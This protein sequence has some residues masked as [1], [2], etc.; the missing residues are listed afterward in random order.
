MD[1][2]ITTGNNSLS[3]IDGKVATAANQTTGNGTLSTISGKVSLAANQITGG[4]STGTG[5][6]DSR[7]VRTVTCSDDPLITHLSSIASNTANIP[8]KGPATA[9]NSLPV[10]FATDASSQ[11]LAGD[12]AAGSSDSGKP[13]KIGGVYSSSPT[14]YA[15]GARVNAAFDHN[16]K[17]ITVHCLSNDVALLGY[18]VH[19]KNSS[20]S[21]N[22]TLIKS[23][24]GLVMEVTVINWNAA[25]R[26]LRLYDKATAPTVGTDIAYR[27]IAL[28]SRTPVTMSFPHGAYFENGIGYSMTTGNTYNDATGVAANEIQ[29]T[30]QWL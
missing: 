16:G 27:V 3:S 30:I 17:Q 1:G 12:V 28:T 26:Y 7:T 9:A 8:A 21:T 14:D 18:N 23:T 29:M 11:P 20:N 6:A 19:K 24:A 2:K 5:T 25:L 4:P 22:A 15:S 10:V 13:V